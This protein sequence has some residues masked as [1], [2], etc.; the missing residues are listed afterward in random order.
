M[1]IQKDNYLKMY[2][3]QGYNEQEFLRIRTF[4]I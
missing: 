4:G 3:I 2:G 1:A